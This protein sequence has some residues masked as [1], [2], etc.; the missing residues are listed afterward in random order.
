M[1]LIIWEISEQKQDFRLEPKLPRRDTLALVHSFDKGYNQG[2]KK[3]VAE[4]F[5]EP[6]MRVKDML[7]L[8]PRYLEMFEYRNGLTDGEIHTL[9]ETGKQFDGIS[10]NR[11]RQLEA[12]VIFEVGQVA[13]IPT[14]FD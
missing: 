11:V 12:R 13:G 8:K 9:S 4:P 10:G 3:L 2:M 7:N 6:Y 5:I 14:P 1:S